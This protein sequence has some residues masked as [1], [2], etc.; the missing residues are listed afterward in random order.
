[1]IGNSQQQLLRKVFE[2]R[3]A[4]KSKKASGK[5]VDYNPCF[6]MKIFY[7]VSCAR[8]NFDPSPLKLTLPLKF[9]KHVLPINEW[10]AKILF[11]SI[12]FPL[13]DGAH[14]NFV[15]KLA[16]LKSYYI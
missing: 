3:V 13:I 7:I 5:W 4:A 12:M 9:D 14:T 16:L 6:G 2:P 11:W 10:V 1:M 8:S 15:V